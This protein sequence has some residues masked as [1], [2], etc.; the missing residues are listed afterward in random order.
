MNGKYAVV[1]AEA[2]CE[3]GSDGRVLSNLLRITDP[4]AME[5]EES[6]DYVRTI[7]QVMA[8]Q[9]DDHRF[10]AEDIRYLHR[11]WLSDIYSWAGE[12]RQVNMVKNGFAFAGALHIPALMQAYERDDLAKYTPCHPASIEDHANAL[13]VTHAELV[14]IHPFREGNGRCARLLAMA[15]SLQAG[16]QKLDFAP[17]DEDMPGYIRAIHSSMTRDYAPMRAIF[18]QVLERS[19][20]A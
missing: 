16:Y 4:E 8:A 14:L 19:V 6:V 17:M 1:G 7:V 11:L 3:P 2:E 15:M 9:N 12:Y 5:E 10:S 18:I 13:A 20:A